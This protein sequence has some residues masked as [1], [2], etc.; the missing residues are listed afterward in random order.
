MSESQ[1]WDRARGDK[2]PKLDITR[3]PVLNMFAA[4][5]LYHRVHDEISQ[6]TPCIAA[7]IACNVA[8]GKLRRCK[9]QT[10]Q[11][12]PDGE[13]AHRRCFTV[14]LSKPAVIYIRSHYHDAVLKGK[15]HHLLEPGY[16]SLAQRS[17]VTGEAWSRVRMSSC[18]LLMLTLT[19]GATR[20][21]RF[22]VLTPLEHRAS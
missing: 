3:E 20:S 15:E 7:Q 16:S 13:P 1:R 2:E 10:S 8:T 4:F 14:P 18:A 12:S 19:Q 21:C 6:S 22:A 9:Q 17:S 5:E 11:S